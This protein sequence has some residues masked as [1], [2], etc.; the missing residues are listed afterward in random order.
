MDN[1]ELLNY[2]RYFR[3]KTQNDKLIVFVGA[4]I[5]K[6][7]EGM[8]DWNELI[9][10]MADAIN[11][12][13][14]NTCKKKTK[15]CKASC[16]FIDVYSNDEFLKIPQYVYNRSKS[17]YNRVL[18]ENI[19][20]DRTIDA[21]LSNAI[22]DLT[23]SHIITTNYDK[24]LENCKNAQGDNYGVIVNDKD[25]LKSQKNKYV[26]KMHGD[27]DDLNT[28]VLKESDYLEYTQ[29][30]ILIEMFVKSLL[31][32]H[33]ILF[34]GYSLN[35]YNIKLI[36]SWIN[37]IRAQNKALD[38]DTKFGYIVL[39]N[40]KTSKVEQKYFEKNNIGVINLYNMPIV[41]DIPKE[42]I[43]DKGKRLYSFLR[44]IGDKSLEHFM[45]EELSYGEAV[46]FMKKHRYLNYKNICN[47][48][49]I[50]KYSINGHE[51]G[52]FSDI[53]YDSLIT[54][55]EN[56]SEN[57]DV[58]QQILFDAGIYIIQLIST[59]SNRRE[60][61]QIKKD[62]NSILNNHS[63]KLYLENKYVELNREVESTYQ[64]N[65][66]EACFYKTLIHHYS[67][68]VFDWFNNIEYNNLN[69]EE[70]VAY[71][72]N[73][74]VLKSRKIFEFKGNIISKYIDGIAD[75]KEEK[76]YDEYKDILNGNYQKLFAIEQ[77]LSKLKGQYY[78]TRHSFFG[79]GS[80]QELFKIRRIALEQYMFYFNNMLFFKDFS[81]LKKILKVYIESIICA[82]GNFVDYTVSSFGFSSKKERYK[83]DVVDVDIMTKFISIK[84]LNA[85]IQEYKVDK[86][87]VDDECV[88]HIVNCF[89][90]VASSILEMS[91]YNRFLEAPHT[92]INCALILQHILLNDEQTKR[93]GEVF[94]L[95]MSNENFAEFFFSTDFP[96]ISLS[97]KIVSESLKNSP[98]LHNLEVVKKIIINPEFKG[99]Y[100]NSNVRRLQSIFST[101][102]NNTSDEETQD[103]IN[104][105][106]LSFEG[107][108]RINVLRLLYKHV[109]NTEYMDKHKKYISDNFNLLDADDI[110]DF[111]FDDWLTITP[112][113]EKNM[114][115]AALEIFHQQQN[116]K[117]VHRYP[118]P[119][120][121]QLELI[122]ILY[123]TEKIENIDGLRE[124]K[125]ASLFLQFF[126]DGDNF[127]Y[128]KV[129]FSDYMWENIAR[130]P[131]F[132]D[133]LI[134]HKNKIIPNIQLRIDM[135]E[136][137][138]FE[139]KVLYGYFMD[140]DKLL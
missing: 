130:Q 87:L 123:I 96:E 127:D 9:I 22:F 48:L 108:E 27:I 89:E 116:N 14:C 29:N 49:N 36:I 114:I 104:E 112:D 92:L 93:V 38:K 75:I 91:L 139:R 17:L 60:Q 63:Y 137:T 10:K 128:S 111:A 134:T 5:S 119:L 12:S 62:I 53:V 76:L 69:I 11:Y 59:S 113:N 50:K 109:K 80:L 64:T 79:G 20:H 84:E 135:E 58:L 83:I 68:E 25:L 66:F 54:F 88:E 74:S 26:I 124:M 47:I 40:K 85:L 24:L 3:E 90:N 95:L 138:E 105:Y 110:F 6:N 8:P 99:Y 18:S 101:F 94:L 70:R 136:A 117:G 122:F 44:I 97:S 67:T 73:D 55:L 19:D 103:E 35:D 34:L 107:K 46:L 15:D 37:Y 39:D 86:F 131:R 133:K 32:D 52:V 13:K 56:N 115:D 77:A 72:F 45:G 30:H 121:N 31:T 33:T 51:L 57:S 125:D 28:I 61:Y 106:I 126:L 4:G 98:P 43:H 41:N 71:L 129:D 7:V 78:N 16:K 118:D 102:I 82:N 65:T 2:I 100:I 132:M 23:P 140:N 21:P 42:L 120:K 1:K 81:D